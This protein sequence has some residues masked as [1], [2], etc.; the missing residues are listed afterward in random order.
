M[1]WKMAKP[2]DMFRVIKLFLRNGTKMGP[3]FSP[4]AEPPGF[5]HPG[6]PPRLEGR[7]A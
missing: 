1:F 6:S 5:A 7:T 3:A 4:G 2:H